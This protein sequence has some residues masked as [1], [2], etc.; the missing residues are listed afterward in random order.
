VQPD[1]AK[2][3]LVPGRCKG[4]VHQK[5]TLG[6][7]GRRV[8]VSR[9]WSLKTLADIRAD[10][11]ARVRAILDGDQAD[12]RPEDD[13]FVYELARPDDPDVPSYQHRIL[14]AIAARSR[15]RDEIRQARQRT[16]AM[17]ASS[18]PQLS[19]TALT[20]PAGVDREAA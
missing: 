9:Q 1:G 19:A 6:F 15:W 2:K 20:T 14:T 17:E 10:N 13:R 12:A 5:T 3:N 11:Q 7:T 16:A 8:L 4:K 18:S